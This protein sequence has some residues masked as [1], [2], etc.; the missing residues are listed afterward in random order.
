MSFDAWYDPGMPKMNDTEAETFVF[1]GCV[2]TITDEFLA[3]LK[4][5][6]KNPPHYLI[7]CGDISGSPENEALKFLFY[8]RVHNC[9]KHELRI[10]DDK[11]KYLSHQQ[12]L[13]A[14]YSKAPR[15]NFT[16]RDG[17]H[18]LMAYQYQ[19]S[20]M[21]IEAAGAKAKALSDAECIEII[22]AVAA[23][24]YFGNWVKN[25]L[26]VSVRAA[27]VKNIEPD[28]QR[29][30]AALAPIQTAGTQVIIVGGNWDNAKN[31][32]ENMTGPDIEVFDTVPFLRGKG[33]TFHT[34]IAYLETKTALLAFLPFW[35]IHS[36]NDAS[37]ERLVTVC[38]EAFQASRQGKTVIA[39]AHAEP[40]WAVHNQ[41]SKD[42][43]KLDEE[44]SKVIHRLDEMLF[45][46]CPDEVVYPHQHLLMRNFKGETVAPN[47]KYVLQVTK[48]GVRLVEDAATFGQGRQIIASY[49]PLQHF[50][51]L[52]IS[53]SGN[54]HPTLFG[55]DRDPVFV[56]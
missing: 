34:E 55:G 28:A 22:K 31:T 18:E 27:L 11:G 2:H 47:T 49:V 8:E 1:I 56:S 32:Q 41:L 17:V 4:E 52:A 37:D 14:V 6:E 10:D 16:L 3:K 42:P 12:I 5:I 30:A 40:N 43:S 25:D 9:A 23:V 35:E 36:Y 53:L 19:L 29:L 7:F 45:E 46:L 13:S 54:H 38:V 20:G 15:P 26:P 50:G 33:I 24:K 39:I 48:L 51:S 21:N 44:R